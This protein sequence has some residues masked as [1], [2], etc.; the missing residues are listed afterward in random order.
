V[1]ED[2]ERPDER[3]DVRPRDAHQQVGARTVEAAQPGAAEPEA[4][5]Q[6][7]AALTAETAPTGRGMAEEPVENPLE[8]AMA[9]SRARYRERWEQI[10][11]GFV[12]EPR[13]TVE[14]ADRLVREVVEEMARACTDERE[15][16][17]GTWS[18]GAADTEVMRTTL[19]RYRHLFGFALR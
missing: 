3:E 1:A 5:E 15:R 12:D 11:A 6:E 17:A 10:Q 14:Q 19:Q 18:A 4:K 13:R 8:T 16:L 9:A 7:A 2:M